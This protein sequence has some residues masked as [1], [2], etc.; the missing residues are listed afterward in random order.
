MTTPVDITDPTIAKAYAHP[1]R[2]QILSLL[3]DRVATP[4]QL[5]T[6]LGAGLST[7]SYHVRQLAALKLIKLV[8]RRMKRGAVEHYY[9]AT[10]RPTITNAAWARVPSIVKRALVGGKIAQTGEEIA[11]AAERGGFDRNDVHFSRTRLR[12][13]PEDWKQV[14]DVFERAL[15]DLD[16]IRTASAAEIEKNPD[17]EVHEASAVMMFFETFVPFDDHAARQA[18]DEDLEDLT[19]HG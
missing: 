4:R 2:V 19:A 17:A 9:T 7:T 10:V 11:A 12:L 18:P 8:K 16:A 1:L 6:E 15:K 14:S 5:A 13:L 3:E